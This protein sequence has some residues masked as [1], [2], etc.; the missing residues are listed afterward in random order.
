MEHSAGA[1]AGAVDFWAKAG[2]TSDQTKAVIATTGNFASANTDAAGS[3]LDMAQAGDILSDTLGQFQLDSAD[4][5]QLMKNTARV[6]DVM[7][8]S[9]NT[10]NFSAVEMFESFK[11]AGPILTAVGGSIEETSALLAVMANAGLKGS[12]AGR[13]LKIATAAINAPTAAQTKLYEKYNIVTQDA[14][15]N[16]LSLTD[17]IGQLDKST[18]GLGTGE[19]FGVFAKMFGRQGVTGF[20]N[21]LSKGENEI[22]KMT[23]KLRDASGETDRLAK[24][25]RTSANAQIKLFWKNLKDLGA[26]V[27]TG[28][29]LFGKLGNSIGKI[30]WVKAATFITD[31]LVPALN[32][33]GKIIADVLYPAFL[34]TADMLETIFAP[35]LWAIEK[36]FGAVGES[37]DGLATVL[38]ILATLWTANQ[39][40]MIAMK[41]TG[42]ISW[43]VRLVTQVTAASAAQTALGTS[44]AA[45]NGVM[46]TQVSRLG[47]LKNGAI[48]VASAFTAGWV[49]G[50]IIH[51]QLVEPLM[52][53][54][55]EL[56]S[57]K[58]SL[59]QTRQKGLDRLNTEQ[60]K[61][62]AR[63]VD[64]AIAGQ[65]TTGKTTG[66]LI[67][68][69]T[70]MGGGL[71]ALQQ[72]RQ[73]EKELNKLETQ[74][75]E[76][77]A[78]FDRK[79]TAENIKR[80]Q[81]GDLLQP[82]SV[83]P[84]QL[85]LGD[86]FGHGANLGQEF[87]VLPEQG[88]QTQMMKLTEKMAAE[89]KQFHNNM[90]AQ[91]AKSGGGGAA[92]QNIEIGPTEIN[93]T[94]GSGDPEEIGRIVKS[95]MKESNR[96]LAAEL[97]RENK[98]VGPSEI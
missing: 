32:T 11:T 23:D 4:P 21:L 60:L 30:D 49:M 79:R 7:S 22:G 78:E 51:D 64:K 73:Q 35:A 6:S 94:V 83:A 77:Q 89:Y 25:T 55:F 10:A 92:V 20:L 90:L 54:Q 91:N 29:D 65:K 33:V 17:I 63:D 28:T 84:S 82:Q 40:G 97:A 96:N 87:G 70:G 69:G 74:K 3:M 48:G 88:S 14:Q 68:I 46:A 13:S 80:F 75:A 5:T 59:D 50:S 93:M 37:G 12:I 58:A 72:F 31:D 47:A 86:R 16:M 76:I 56:D 24:I 8:A 53:A 52:K 81:S 85:D 67:S 98:T 34:Q 61:D 71:G 45:T 39:V 19:R 2:K 15:G 62:E 27:I 95:K 42:M 1:V 36:V 43:F 57:L 41:S 66:D 44:T 9:A 26:R 18:Q 38:A